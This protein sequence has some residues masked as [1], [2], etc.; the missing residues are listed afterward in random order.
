M[1]GGFFTLVSVMVMLI[2]G[3]VLAGFAVSA[4]LGYKCYS[5]G[6]TNNMACFMLSGRHDLTIRNR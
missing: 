6:D 3:I 2:F 1:R 5:S 4:Y